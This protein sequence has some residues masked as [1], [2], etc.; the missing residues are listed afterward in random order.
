MS[1]NEFDNFFEMADGITAEASA[2]DDEGETRIPDVAKM[3]P[4]DLHAIGVQALVTKVVAKGDVKA[5]EI[6]VKYTEDQLTTADSDLEGMTPTELIVETNKVLEQL[7]DYE[8]KEKV[9]V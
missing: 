7:K 2:F 5:A 8:M 9:L 1:S 3:S 6:L 4:A